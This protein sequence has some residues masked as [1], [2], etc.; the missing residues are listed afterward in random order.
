MMDRREHKEKFVI[1]GHEESRTTQR[2][3]NKIKDKDDSQPT[4]SLFVKRDTEEYSRAS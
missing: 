3:L 2:R 1:T 4:S